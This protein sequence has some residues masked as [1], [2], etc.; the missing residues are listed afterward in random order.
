MKQIQA[1]EAKA[2]FSELLDQV[3]Q[4]ETIAIT[5]HG[6]VVARIAPPENRR[7]ADVVQAIEELKE[8]RKGSGPVTIEE[9]LAWR[10]EGRRF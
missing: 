3:E 5:R 7:P 9:I 8:L 1:S 4:G 2:K 10:D 6:K